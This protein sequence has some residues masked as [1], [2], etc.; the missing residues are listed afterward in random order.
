VIL[1]HAAGD[2]AAGIQLPEGASIVSNPAFGE[3]Q[4]T[5]LRAGLRAARPDA[6]AAVFLLGDQPGIRSEAIADVVAAW[7]AGAGPVVQASYGGRGA[8]PTLFDRSVWEEV[9][10]ATGDQGARTV[11]AAHPEWRSAVEVSGSVP[12]DID[13]E[14]DYLRVKEA[15][16]RA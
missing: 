2:V 3:G 11:L 10:K 13:T 14:A 7:R 12:D 1:G 16:G 15:F 8:H 4:S 6:R 5:S 9:E